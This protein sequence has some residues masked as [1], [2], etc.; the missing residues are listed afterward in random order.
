MTV[1]DRAGRRPPT[2]RQRGPARAA[3]CARGIRPR[4]AP[5]AASTP[6]TP[7]R[8]RRWPRRGGRRTGAVPTHGATRVERR[9][10]REQAGSPTFMTCRRSAQWG[11]VG[12][13]E[14]C[15]FDNE[16][17]AAVAARAAVAA[18]RATERAAQWAELRHRI[19]PPSRRDSGHGRAGGRGA[20]VHDLPG[21]PPVVGR[22]PLRVVRL[23]H[24]RPRCG[25]PPR[26]DGAVRP[27]SMGGPPPP[28]L[29]GGP[30][31]A[32]P[33]R[34]RAGQARRAPR[35]VGGARRGSSACWP[36]W[37]RPASW[38]R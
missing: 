13:C 3:G 33:R 5:G 19:A 30:R 36:G 27:P 29:L 11:P 2:R 4:P 34:R 17:E 32:P 31:P 15:D 14:W 18:A 22:P 38:R 26:R 24:E 12:L 9:A 21:L 16:D 1:V 20:P 10:A 6:A 23:R 37:P 28:G 7:T 35:A 25:A 8:W